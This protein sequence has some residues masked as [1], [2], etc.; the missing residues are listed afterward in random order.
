MFLFFQEKSS[1]ENFFFHI[2]THLRSFLAFQK[3][4]GGY[5]QKI[6]HSY[7]SLTHFSVVFFTSFFRYV[8]SVGWECLSYL[9]LGLLVIRSPLRPFFFTSLFRFIISLSRSSRSSSTYN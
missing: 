4:R 6:P 8:G 3:L 7:A 1:N 2:V 5:F 9:C